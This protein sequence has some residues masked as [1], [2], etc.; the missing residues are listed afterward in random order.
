MGNNPRRAAA[1]RTLLLLQRAIRRVAGGT[2]S[3]ALAPYAITEMLEKRRL[4]SASHGLLSKLD[5]TLTY[6]YQDYVK[7][8][9]SDVGMIEIQTYAN[10]GDIHN[11]TAALKKYDATD[12]S[13]SGRGVDALV[14]ISDLGKIAKLGSMHF[15]TAASDVVNA[16][17]VTSQGD[18]AD[19][20]ARRSP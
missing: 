10:T 16:G 5:S 9:G 13:G 20:A 4:L 12:I 1:A 17:P 7:S 19:I 11:L 3:G 2:S 18:T 6:A 15:A 8:D 14:P